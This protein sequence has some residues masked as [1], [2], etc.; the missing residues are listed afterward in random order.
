MEKPIDRSKP[1]C[2]RKLKS[3]PVCLI[4]G[5]SLG[6]A[7]FTTA[8]SKQPNPPISSSSLSHPKASKPAAPQ[9]IHLG[10]LNWTLPAKWELNENQAQVPEIFM[11][12]SRGLAGGYFSINVSALSEWD[13]TLEQRTEYLENYY[14]AVQNT[15]FGTPE[16]PG[17]FRLDSSRQIE[18]L[19]LLGQPARIYPILMQRG[20]NQLPGS[21]FVCASKNYNYFFILL[22]DPEKG[23]ARIP[24]FQSEIRTFI[25]SATPQS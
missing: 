22:T 4:L 11:D 10:D 24:D 7:S 14:E 5:L 25:D 16:A 2:M 3:I 8:C 12:V 18:D 20:E 19:T 6:F 21:V 15:L 17:T 13:I 23:V 9:L 1:T